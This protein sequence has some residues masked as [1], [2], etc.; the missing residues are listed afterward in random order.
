MEPS[1]DLSYIDAYNIYSTMEEYALDCGV[2]I[3]QFETF[4]DLYEI[5]I[6]VLALKDLCEKRG[7]KVT[8]MCSLSFEENERTLMGNTPRQ[9]A[10]LLTK[11]CVDVIGSNCGFGGNKMVSVIR[12]MASYTDLPVLAKP[13]AGLPMNVDGKVVYTQEPVEFADICSQ[14]IAAGANII[15]G[16][17]GTTPSHISSMINILK[18]KTIENN[19]KVV[20]D[21]KNYE[22]PVFLYPD[23]WDDDSIYD[24]A[25]DCLDNENDLICLYGV[26]CDEL[27]NSVRIINSVTKADTAVFCTNM[28]ELEES[29]KRAPILSDIW[30]PNG[31]DIS[32]TQFLAKKYNLNI[33]KEDNYNE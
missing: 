21:K 2:D 1:G 7:I 8:I 30:L 29:I 19:S 5:K 32:D 15:G 16:C 14:L 10:E 11:L 23:E 28:F 24:L 26:N 31:V 25:Y 9:C 17:C 4:T 13:N 33:I 27:A 20:Y 22:N 6:A 3:F 12:E 18:D